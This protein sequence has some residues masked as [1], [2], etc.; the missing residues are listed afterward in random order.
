M[1]LEAVKSRP[2][3]LLDTPEEFRA[4]VLKLLNHSEEILQYASEE[5][6]ND[7][8]LIDMARNK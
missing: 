4:E 3:A 7:Q 8:E 1:V 6:Q 2:E 5:L